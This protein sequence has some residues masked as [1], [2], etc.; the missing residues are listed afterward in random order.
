MSS[1]TSENSEKNDL[2]IS[3]QILCK[4]SQTGSLG[5]FGLFKGLC[6]I[7]EIQELVPAKVS[8]HTYL[9]SIRS[10]ERLAM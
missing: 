9:F 8:C 2:I 3:L 1:S 4:A 5:L 7:R 6:R 10:Q